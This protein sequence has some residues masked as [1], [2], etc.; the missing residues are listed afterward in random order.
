GGMGPGVVE[1][2]GAPLAYGIVHGF[3][4]GAALEQIERVRGQLGV[5]VQCYNV[6]PVL[7]FAEKRQCEEW[8]EGITEQ[9]R[10]TSVDGFPFQVEETA[11]ASQRLADVDGDILSLIG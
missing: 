4:A 9:R 11:K 10:G 3:G 1:V 7:R 8:I 5:R 6:P 2:V